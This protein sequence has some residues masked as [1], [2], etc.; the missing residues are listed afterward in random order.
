MATLLGL[1]QISDVARTF[2]AYAQDTIS[3][4]QLVY[5]AS[6]NDVV[7]A[8]S[9]DAYAASDIAVQKMDAAANDEYVVGIALETATSGNPITVA[10]EGIFILA[11]Q[12][13]I[14]AGGGI[15]PSNDADAFCNSVTATA[16]TEEE[17]KIGKALTGASASGKY[18][19]ALVRI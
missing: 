1:Q 15:S 5:A 14:T 16:D 13:A 10:T 6:D 2:T 8:G 3:G 9:V 4:G 11:A 17:F 18:L 7:E 19:V 12:D